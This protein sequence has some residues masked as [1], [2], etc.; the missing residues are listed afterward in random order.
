MNITRKTN[1]KI[2]FI[3]FLLAF[4]LRV[5]RLSSVPPSL[6][7]D[8]AASAYNAYT[9]R[10]W[11]KD[12][13]GNTLPLVFKSFRDDKHPVHIY[14]TANTYIFLGVNDFTTRLPSAFIGSITVVFLYLL[15]KHLFKSKLAGLYS[16][17]LLCFSMYHVFYSRGLWEANFALGFLVIGL[18]VFY[19]ALRKSK[20]KFFPWAYMFFGISLLSYHSAKIVVIGLVPLVT[21][22]YIKDLLKVK[23]IFFIS[24]ATFSFFI[25]IIIL[26]PRLLGL[27][28]VDQ[29]KFSNE[30]IQETTLFKN[31][32]N[33]HLGYL[34]VTFDNYQKY[35]TNDYLFVNGDQSPRGFM[36]DRG[37]FTKTLG[38]LSVIGIIFLLK[39][40]KFKE[41][42]ILVSWV[43]LAPI[44]GALSAQMP[45]A[46]RA[47][48]M[49]GG[50]QLLAGFGL[51][52]MTQIVKHRYLKYSIAFVFLA[53]FFYESVGT[54]NHYFNNF[55]G[56]N[57][58]DWQ[59]G[60][61]EVVGFVKDNPKYR[62]VYMTKDRNQP[63]IFFLYYLKYDLNEFLNTVKYD[64]GESKSYNT[65]E[66][67][68]IYN[69]GN[70]DEIGSEPINGYLYIVT[71]N[72]YE[73]LKHKR[74]FEV[75]KLI[76]YPNGEDA[77]YI[78]AV[79]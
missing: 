49:L 9:I 27:A 6:N 8:E 5:Y 39:E 46:T 11:A 42:I 66:S 34:E 44:P 53:F 38:F 20:Y 74:L 2:L 21:L 56:K 22:F 37:M 41:V 75:K 43:A 7:W 51:Y 16:S 14:L 72:K 60:M 67:F 32:N 54:I 57:P 35:F 58:H 69:F 40:R 64:M 78:V 24:L 71:P 23:R 62:K 17:I 15:G 26:Q 63:Y 77:F 10:N 28:R 55:A 65:V 47:I 4:I 76:K 52:S 3:V 29:T 13:W 73:G 50:L 68:G 70:W 79:N 1:I 48:F 25:L 36:S 45:R 61:K 30:D 19:Y 59:Y 31:T 12:E 33:E 18:A